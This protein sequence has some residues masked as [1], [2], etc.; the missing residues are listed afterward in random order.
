MGHNNI[1]LNK[2]MF[3]RSSKKNR[4][5]ISSSSSNNNEGD[6]EDNIQVLS[7]VIFVYIFN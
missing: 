7:K 6:G 5:K 2:Y 4:V 3:Q 1:V